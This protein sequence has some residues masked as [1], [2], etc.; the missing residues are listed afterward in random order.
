MYQQAEMEKGNKQR[1]SGLV[2]YTGNLRT[3]EVGDLNFETT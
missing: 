1:K 3:R 2:V